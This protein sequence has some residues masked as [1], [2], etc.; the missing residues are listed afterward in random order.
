MWPR[1]NPAARTIWLGRWLLPV[2]AGISAALAFPP[3]NISQMGWVCLV[4]LLFAVENCGWGEAFR[5]GY[6]AGLVFFGMTVWWIVNVT[7]PGTVGLIAYLALY[8][9]LAAGLFAT[10]TRRIAGTSATAGGATSDSVLL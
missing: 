5:R 10:I 1:M 7:M 4:P 8:F 9:G 3:F 2:A 6:I